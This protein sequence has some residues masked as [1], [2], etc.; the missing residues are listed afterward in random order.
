MPRSGLGARGSTEP[1]ARPNVGRACVGAVLE[2]IAAAR[3]LGEARRAERFG[4]VRLDLELL[5]SLGVQALDRATLFE[6]SACRRKRAAQRAQARRRGEAK[7]RNGARS[8]LPA[9]QQALALAVRI[10]R[11]AAIDQ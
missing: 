4:G 10:E 2:R 8:R 7:R 6:L 1:F 9:A 11:H 3:E 5:S